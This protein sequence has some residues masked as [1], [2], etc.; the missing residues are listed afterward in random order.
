MIVV[1]DTTAIT[2]LLKISEAG[3]L[4][5]LFDEVVIPSAVHTEL[6]SYHRE[7]P[8]WLVVKAVSDYRLLGEASG[9]LD[10]GEAEA[11]I[12]AKEMGADLLIIDEKTGRSIAESIDLHCIGLA[13]TLL[14]AKQRHL[15]PSLGRMLDRLE[16]EALLGPIMQ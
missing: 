13:G 3:L 16:N 15:V 2:S 5:E 4:E 10:A 8:A 7:L 6:L 11:I 9:K 14:L 1:S 12:L